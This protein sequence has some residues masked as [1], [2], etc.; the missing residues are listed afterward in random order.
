M[1]SNGIPANMLVAGKPAN[2]NDGKDYVDPSTLATCF[3]QAKS[4][5]VIGGAMVWEYPDANAQWIQQAR[6]SAWPVG[7]SDAAPTSGA[8]DATSSGASSG[9]GTQAATT[10]PATSAATLAAG[11]STAASTS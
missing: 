4:Q 6:T 11:G 10:T 7:S 3:A 8:T 9:A 2:A 1:V 5:N